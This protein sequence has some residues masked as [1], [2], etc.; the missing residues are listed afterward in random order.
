M[1]IHI[2]KR[3]REELYRQRMAVNAFA[4]KINRSRNVVYN[5]FE[6]ESVDTELLNKIGKVLGC[7]FFS[8]YSSQKEYSTEG[9][10]TFALRETEP[11]YG[12][13]SGDTLSLLQQ[14]NQ[15]LKNEISYLKKIIS[16]LEKKKDKKQKPKK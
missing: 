3:I 9:V 1:A 2:G 7:D 12:N 13:K 15:M 14:Q 11:A 16:L 4:K 8:L 5:I 10:R 6:R